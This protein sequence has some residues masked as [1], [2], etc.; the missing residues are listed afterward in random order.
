MH[1][2]GVCKHQKKKKKSTPCSEK[3]CRVSTAGRQEAGLY[4][5]RTEV[6]KD[7]MRRGLGQSSGLYSGTG[8][9]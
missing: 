6:G 8:S 7:S 3:R 5:V 1:V 4:L 9:H 2:C